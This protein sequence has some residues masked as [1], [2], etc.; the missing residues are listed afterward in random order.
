MLTCATGP[1]VECRD[2]VELLRMRAAEQDYLTAF[3]YLVSPNEVTPLTYGELDQ[4]ARAIATLLQ[5]HDAQGERVLLLY[6]P[7]LD[8][9]AGFFTDVFTGSVREPDR[10]RLTLS[11]EEHLHFDHTWLPSLMAS[12]G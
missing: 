2:L 12:V 6:P 1:G 4:R 7:G 8:F 11:I 9:I 3:E 5:E 10:E